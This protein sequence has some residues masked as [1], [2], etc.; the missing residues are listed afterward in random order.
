M[1]EY[2][3]EIQQLQKAA[4]AQPQFAAP[5]QSVAG[6]VVNLIGTGLDFYSKK[7]AQGEL[8]EVQ[9]AQSAQNKRLAIGQEN[10][11]QVR[12]L[13]T[14]PNVS[15]SMV[16]QKE[17]DLKKL[18]SPEEWMTILKRNNTVSKTTT[19]GVMSSADLAI[20]KKQDARKALEVEVAELL[21]HLDYEVDIN[22]SDADLYQAKLD[23]TVKLANNQAKKA[24]MDLRNARLTAEGK[25]SDIKADKFFLDYGELGMASYSKVSRSIVGNADF[26]KPDQVQLYMTK[27]DELRQGYINEAVKAARSAGIRTN[28]TE[29]AERLATELRVFD[30]TSRY[31]SRSDI[32]TMGANQMK[33]TQQNM[34]FG[35]LNSESADAR[36]LA[37]LYML[38]DSFAADSLGAKMM[39]AQ[40]GALMET[41]G[42]PSW[43]NLLIGDKANPNATPTPTEVKEAKEAEKRSNQLMKDTFKNADKVEGGF[44]DSTKAALGRV[45]KEK[46]QGS[47]ATREAMITG[48]GF[49]TYIQS[50]AGGVPEALLLP[51][52]RDEILMGIVDYGDEFLRRIVPN[53]LGTPIPSEEAT[54]TK[55]LFP[56]KRFEVGLPTTKAMNK[57]N[58]L[59]EDTLRVTWKQ[60][61]PI[62]NKVKS[63]NKFIGE[64]FEA[65]D[66][67]GATED[68]IKY[69][70][71]EVY[72]SFVVANP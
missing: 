12:L 5:S 46:L 58:V 56:S 35:L 60:D 28:P 67:M 11:R 3:R 16:L 66:K 17:N 6:D 14:Q 8:E 62:S 55:P 21:P 29:V 45:M 22:A 23:G 4:N 71:N 53:L 70:K 2:T 33:A 1:T 24:E 32:A 44:P 31:L 26:T 43:Y 50:I 30:D 20:Q 37:T 68:E 7:K 57:M 59:E 48:S 25:E 18:Y 38:G 13:G 64:Y 36:E 27:N 49:N 39:K 41:I 34:I 72:R 65:L 10:L 69:L 63:Y 9:A 52:D 47:K 19:A 51:E 54:Y 40:A 15:G 61:A 42:G